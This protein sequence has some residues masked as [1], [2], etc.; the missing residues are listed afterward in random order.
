MTVMLG[1]AI[2]VSVVLF[3]ALAG[4][5]L[6]RRRS[7]AFRHW[8]LTAAVVSAAAVP[9]LMWVLPSQSI[10][11]PAQVP[12]SPPPIAEPPSERYYEVEAFPP[13]VTPAATS[14]SRESVATVVAAPTTD[15][16]VSL[17][18]WLWIAGVGVMLADLAAGIVHLLRLSRRAR[19]LDSG[20][21]VQLAEETSRRYGISNR[22]QLLET[23]G[24][25]VLATWGLFRPQLLLPAGAASWPEE[26]IRVVLHHELAHV[27]RCDWLTQMF[28]E[29]LRAFYWFNPLCWVACEAL[30]QESEQACDDIALNCG[31]TGPDYAQQLLALTVALQHPAPALPAAMSMARP[32]T[33][34][35][36]FVALL[37]PRENR[38]AVTRLSA[39]VT[40][41]AVLAV[42]GSIAPLRVGAEPEPLPLPQPAV[43]GV[44]AAEPATPAASSALQ[45]VTSALAALMTQAPAPAVSSASIEGTVVKFGTGEPI[46]GADVSLQTLPGPGATS[47]APPTV[48]Q[49]GPDGK[50]IFRNLS[51]GTYRLV[52]LRA[53]GHAVA[54]YGQRTPNGRGRPIPVADGQRVTNVTLAMMPTGSISGRILD[55]DGEP[56]GRAQVQALQAT[57]RE[58]RKIL[59][60]VQSVQTNDVGEYR[61][62]WLPPGS[63]YLSARPE[64]PRRRNVP[65]YVNYPGTGGVFEQAASPV[66][67]HRAL[68]NGGVS[69]ESFVL[70]YFP[71]TTDFTTASPVDV[72]P[73]DS[74]GGLN[75]GVS[76]GQ[77]RSRHVRGRAV[78]GNGQPVTTGSV[79]AIPRS[80][81][82]NATIPSALLDSN[83]RFD[84]GGVVPGGYYIVA[85][86]PVGIVPIDVGGSDVENIVVTSKPGFDLNGRI[87]IEG[88]TRLESDPELVRLHAPC[89]GARGM[90]P[91]GLPAGGAQCLPIRFNFVSEPALLGFPA[92]GVGGVP[93]PGG[94]G[95]VQADGTFILRNLAARD[96]R[97]A[98]ATLP[99]DWYVKSARLGTVDPFATLVSFAMKP[100]EQLEVV[101]GMN[102]G[103]LEGR[104]V[105]PTGKPVPSATVALI[106][107]ASKRDRRHFHRSA[108]SDEAGQFRFQGIAPGDYKVFAWEEIDPS[109]WLDPEVIRPVENRGKAIRINADGRDTVEAV[110]I[111][112]PR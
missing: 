12:A 41:A 66:V 56:L 88:K 54:E 81:H 90:P 7:A 57:H 69:E 6:L 59:K 20:R 89:A 4:V 37:N 63:Y 55:R 31:I 42:A 40:I 48:L 30:V 21:W 74:I 68:D 92:D 64:D 36:R 91:G 79:L 35:R 95:A 102:G 46:A 94:N 101:I 19:A 80:L 71:G 65:L 87:T 82:P 110:V 14:P 53:E 13:G 105:D 16:P 18:F 85:G 96:Y 1:Y 17:F 100:E 99:P 44:P 72:R 83:G 70:V 97:L 58:G 45:T 43:P 75:F 33:L 27:R 60:I 62:F 112:A 28:A 67:T 2:K 103:R 26:R 93:P 9:L 49:S 98:T 24:N 76:A 109:A 25:S 73:G 23:S 29:T 10:Q 84:I 111:P 51:A 38:A 11:I 107:E 32:S 78:D 108:V 8:L 61:L 106:P 3:A 86:N 104:V 77:V 5:R 39:A 50:F 15:D 47:I 52:A 22:V 34:E